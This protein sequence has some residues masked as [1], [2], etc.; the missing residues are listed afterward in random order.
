MQTA[1]MNN[2]NVEE[3]IKYILEECRGKK[4]L[5]PKEAK[6]FLPWSKNLPD[7]VKNPAKL[8]K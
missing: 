1:K 5:T 4:T 3:Y 7:Y 2:L 8:E 6:R